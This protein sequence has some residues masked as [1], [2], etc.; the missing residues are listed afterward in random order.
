MGCRLSSCC[1]AQS[2]QNSRP[3]RITITTYFCYV[4]RTKYNISVLLFKEMQVVSCSLST[5]KTPTPFDLDIILSSWG[6][7]LLLLRFYTERNQFG[8]C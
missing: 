8:K 1:S 5:Q 3:L 7:F 6:C 2:S 4:V